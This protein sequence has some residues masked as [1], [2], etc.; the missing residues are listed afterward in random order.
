ML[1]LF[2]RRLSYDE[3][4]Q[5]L[6]ISPLTV[7]THAMNVYKKLGVKGLREAV[8]LGRQIGLLVP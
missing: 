8:L 5:R 2:G 7:K 4:V 3:V 6:V 1:E